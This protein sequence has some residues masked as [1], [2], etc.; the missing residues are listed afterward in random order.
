MHFSMEPVDDVPT[1][2]NVFSHRA[3][4]AA[5]YH[6]NKFFMLD[7]MSDSVVTNHMPRIHTQDQLNQLFLHRQVFCTESALA[8]FYNFGFRV[9]SSKSINSRKSLKNRTNITPS[10]NGNGRKAQKTLT[11]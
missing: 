7:I 10:G 2:D 3:L 11:R 8:E 1:D 9:S 6:R 5:R 4:C